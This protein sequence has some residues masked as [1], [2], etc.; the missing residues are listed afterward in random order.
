MS[1]ATE[2]TCST[3]EE[4]PGFA[5]FSFGFG[6]QGFWVE[7]VGGWQLVASA[8]YVNLVDCGLGKVLPEL[9]QTSLFGVGL[10]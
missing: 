4:G 5:P 2:P 6:L 3:Y 9:V 10:N 7:Q 1:E 8:C